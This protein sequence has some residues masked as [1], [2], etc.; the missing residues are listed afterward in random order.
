MGQVAA[1]VFEGGVFEGGGAS[2]T[3]QQRSHQVGPSHLAP[4]AVAKLRA[5]EQDQTVGGLEQHEGGA[6]G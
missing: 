3:C 4:D 6:L 1:G 2:A 5:G